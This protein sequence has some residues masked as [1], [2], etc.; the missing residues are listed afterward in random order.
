MQSRVEKRLDSR[1]LMQSREQA[2]SCIW[3]Q[4]RVVK[5]AGQYADIAE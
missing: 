2:D 4:S 1:I 3:M 5:K